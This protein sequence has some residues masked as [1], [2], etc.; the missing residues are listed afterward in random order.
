MPF[1]NGTK[2]RCWPDTHAIR[3]LA[4]YRIPDY[5]QMQFL[6][7]YLKPGDNVLDVGANLGLYTVLCASLVGA[8][9]S[10]DSVE[11]VPETA[12][13]LLS[14]VALNMFNT[15]V[16]V[17]QV[18]VGS[19]AEWAEMTTDREAANRMVLG[20]TSPGPTVRVPVR[21]IDDIAGRPDYAL[22]KIDVEGREWD[23]FRTAERILASHRPPVWIVEI[24]GGLFEYGH[25]VSPF[26]EWMSG[27]GF[28]PWMY[29][30]ETRAFR[31]MVDNV[32]GDV[33]FIAR[34]GMGLIQQR[35]PGL[36]FVS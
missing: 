35:I 14:N 30:L 5:I 3:D 10:V 28:D 27:R 18:A 1:L 2:I 8:E 23:A 9:G 34:D 6:L 15:R 17:H 31:R 33:F 12:K 36:T 7:D 19:D 26:V 20:A 24:N 16:R 29:D 32:W 13:R 4:Y 21:N 11:A 25:Q 22:G